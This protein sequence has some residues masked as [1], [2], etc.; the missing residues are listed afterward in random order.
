[1]NLF[2]NGLIFV[3]LTA[4]VLSATH[5]YRSAVS[6]TQSV[7]NARLWLKVGA[8]AIVA[9]SGLLLFLLMQHDF[10][11]GY[12]YSY[13]SRDLPLHFLISSFYAGQEGSFLFWVLCSAVIGL[14]L[15]RH[16]GRREVEPWVMSVYMGV[17]TFLILLLYAKTPFLSVWEKIPQLP[18][19]QL[20]ADGNGL[21]PLLQNFWMVIHPPVLFVGFAAMAVPFAYAVASMWKKSYALTCSQ[22]IG[23]LLFAVFVLGTGIMLGGYWAY[24]VLGWGGYWGWDPVENSSLVPW[25]T[26]VALVHTLIVQKRTG[27]FLRTNLAL[28]IISFMLVVY[29]TFLTRSGVLGD[30][31]VHSFTDPGAGVYWLLI[32]FLVAIAV[33][34]FGFMLKRR[35]ELRP[36]KSDNQFVSRETALAAGTIAL[37]LSA[38]VILFGTSLPLLGKSTVDISFYNTMNLPL[39]IVMALFIG[40]SLYTQWG[41]DDWKE[42][43]RRSLKWI[44]ISLAAGAVLFVLGTRDVG[45][46]ALVLTSLFAVLVNIEFGWKQG[47]LDIA[48]IGG[49][50]AH[51]GLGVFLLGV[52]AS[53]KYSTTGQVS[54]PKGVPQDV[55]G[56]TLTY[57]GY[58]PTPDRK[59]AFNI[60]VANEGR[61]FQLSPLMFDAGEQGTMKNPDIKS[62]LTSDFYISPIALEQSQEGNADHAGDVYTIEK[63]KTVSVGGFKATFVKFDMNAHSENSMASGA[64]G[65]MAVGSVL[66]VTDGKT[67]EIVTPV[68]VYGADGQQLSKPSESRLLNATVQ[69]VSMNVGGM[70]GAKSSTVTIGVQ[71][72]G[73]GHAH[74]E[75]LVVEASVKPFISLVWAGSVVM[76]LG[77]IL[78]TQRRLREL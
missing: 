62:F 21:N 16:T 67:K 19:G 45:T 63:G 35:S 69:L 27:K 6:S 33:V 2:G 51:I 48:A 18:P 36:A 55:L 20:P 11:N 34:G 8:A 74:Q 1:M 68:T 22:A 76:F 40:F 26:G 25:L 50:L 61:T 29:S 77:V 4:S 65:D 39:A 73:D 60:N 66:E 56:H 14:A 38:A 15:M 31:S 53:G 59:Y 72:G 17:Q 24:G 9:L 12:V 23:W 64:A 46:F 3:A 13:S 54:L 47:R 28:A 42:I 57:V 41:V 49:K 71:R 7:K 44:W 10:S 58:E 30:S 78:A 32:A 75:A 52:I 37:V 70:D 5:Y 43:L